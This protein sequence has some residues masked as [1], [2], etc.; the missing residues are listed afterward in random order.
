MAL[1]GQRSVSSES[2]LLTSSLEL[3]PPALDILMLVAPNF[4]TLTIS[5]GNGIERSTITVRIRPHANVELIVL[6]SHEGRFDTQFFVG[7][8]IVVASVS[9]RFHRLFHFSGCLSPCFEVLASNLVL[10]PFVEVR[11]TVGHL[12]TI[13]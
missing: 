11:D 4:L 13:A 2:S 1:Y 3:L 5:H 8:Q 6:A 10:A 9:E 12:E 7:Y